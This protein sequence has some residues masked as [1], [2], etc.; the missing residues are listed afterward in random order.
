MPTMKEIEESVQSARTTDDK[1]LNEKAVRIVDTILRG[2]IQCL[3]VDSK[4][5]CRL[6]PVAFRG[7][8]GDRYVNDYIVYHKH[9][10]AFCVEATVLASPVIVPLQLTPNF[11]AL[12]WHI[13]H[14]DGGIAVRGFTSDETPEDLREICEFVTELIEASAVRS[15]RTQ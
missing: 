2:V 7:D 3:G 6:R 13:P 11:A 5:A 15:L 12:N 14:P 4:D 1:E 9:S 10:F 8:L